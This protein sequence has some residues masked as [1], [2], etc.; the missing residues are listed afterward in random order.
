MTNAHHVQSGPLVVKLGGKALDDPAQSPWLWDAL[1]TLHR[2]HAGGVVLVH[3]GG[4]A[5][6][7]KLARL[8]LQTERREGIRITPA[9][10][11][12]EIVAVLA[13]SLNKSLVGWVQRSGVAAVGLC[14]G[15][16]RSARTVKT[17][18]YEFDPGHVGEIAGGDPRLLVT[19]LDG[20]FMP[21]LCSIGLDD[22]GRPLNINADEAAA[23]IA[24]LLH[25]A[26]LIL[27]T[28]V[29]GVLDGSGRLMDELGESQIETLIAAGTIHG[30]MIPKV[31]GAAQAARVAGVAA[32]IASWNGPEDL[33]RLARRERA[34]TRIVPVT[35]AGRGGR[36][37][38][39]VARL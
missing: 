18:R 4:G 11:L 30:G 10:H 13:G 35:S 2:S 22:H 7:R 6:D 5:V 15:D 12:D 19:L 29:P 27:L 36:P 1:C 23:G 26:G 21:V 3:G 33:L 39:A 34:G 8:G 31:R 14:L 28:D 9:D 25:A 24:A 17:S 32:T 38:A 20:G 16:G 37:V